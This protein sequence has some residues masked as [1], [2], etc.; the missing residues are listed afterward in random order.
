MEDRQT[1]RQ[2]FIINWMKSRYDD[3]E[4]VIITIRWL[5][6]EVGLDKKDI[7]VLFGMRELVIG[8]IIEYKIEP[9]LNPYIIYGKS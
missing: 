5:H 6:E 7:A 3:I 1:P 8:S 2:K 9:A 4:V